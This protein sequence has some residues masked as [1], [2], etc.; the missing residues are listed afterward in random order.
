MDWNWLGFP[1][2]FS[3]PIALDGI[4]GWSLAG[5]VIAALIKLKA[6]AEAVS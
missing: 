3:M 2:E 5:L 1:L 4:I 6:V